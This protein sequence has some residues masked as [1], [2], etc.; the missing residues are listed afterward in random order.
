MTLDS[1][2]AAAD[3]YAF[4]VS[5]AQ[6]RL[7]FLDQVAPNNP[8]YNIPLQIPIPAAVDP[9]HL[10]AAINEIV[11]RH[12]ALR[13]SF[14]IVEG[15]PLQVVS[16]SLRV[17][18]DQVDISRYSATQ[19]DELTSTLAT[20]EARK[21][22]DLTRPPLLRAVLLRRG[23]A[24]F[25]LLLT[26]HHIVA[27]GWSVGILARELA[28]LYAAFS[29]GQPSPLPELP[30]QYADFAVWQRDWLRGERLHSLLEYW[31]RKLDKAPQLAMPTDR[32]RPT[33]LT[34]RGAFHPVTVSAE[35]SASVRELSRRADATL[36]MTLL[37]AFVGLLHRYTDQ[38]DIVVGTPIANRNRDEIEGLIGFFV[39]SLVMRC[40][41]MDNPTFRQLL[42][43]VRQECLDAYAHQ[44]LPFEKLVEHL[45]TDR[46]PS[47]NPLFQVTFQV[48]NAPT[49]ATPGLMTAPM[50]FDV[51]RGSAIFDIAFTMLD[52]PGSLRGMLEYST[53]LFDRE[54]IARLDVHY[55][56]FLQAV[57]TNPDMPLAEVSFIT[58]RE[59]AAVV[60]LAQQGSIGPVP[61]VLDSFAATVRLCADETA[62]VAH[63]GQLSYR[64]LDQQSDRLAQH[65]VKLGVGSGSRVGLL[66]QPSARVVVGM[67]GVLKAGAA[68]VPLDPS[69]PRTRLGFVVRDA[70]LACILTD[71]DLAD[72]L[73][74]EG[75]PRITLDWSGA[76]ISDVRL[77]L[78]RPCSPQDTAYVIYTSGSTGS[79]KGVMIPR[80]AL[81]NH[82][83]WMA[84]DYPL[85][86][87]DRVLQR[88]PYT[89]DASVW[90]FFAPMIS[91]ARLVMLE[92]G[93]YRDPQRIAAAVVQHRITILQTVPALLRLL[94]E[95]PDFCGASHLRTVFCGGDVLTA[96]LRDR[97]FATLNADLCN[98]YGPTESTIDATS[99]RCGRSDIRSVV[100]I[101]RAISNTETYVLDRRRE[102][103]PIGV[104]GDLY[105]GGVGLATGYVGHPRLTAERFVP[106][107]FGTRPSS[108][109]YATGDRVRILT[110]GNL[111]FL[112]RRDHQVKLRGY[113]VELGEIEEALSGC[114]GV[115]QCAVTVHHAGASDPRLIGYVVPQ[116]WE[117]AVA[118]VLG[119]AEADHVDRWGSIYES[120]YGDLAP[121]QDVELNFVGWN[122]S[123]TGAPINADEMTEWRARTVDGILGLRPSRVLEIGCGTGLILYPVAP[124]CQRYVGTDFSARSID[125]LRRKLREAGD[126]MSHVELL[127]RPA[128]DFS[129]LEDETFDLVV[130][131]SVIQYF[132][133]ERY[134]REV[135]AEAIRCLAP[136]GAVFVG[137][138]RNLQHLDAFH[139]TVEIS[140]A[141]PG[142]PA[143]ELAHRVDHRVSQERELVVHPAL[144]SA[145]AADWPEIGA[146]DLR[147]KRSEF[148]NELTL[149]RY[150]V[151]L[152]RDD[153]PD[154]DLQVERL[155]WQRTPLDGAGLPQQLR[156]AEAD[157]VVVRGVPNRRVMPALKLVAALSDAKPSIHA[158]DLAVLMERASNDA[159]APEAFFEM[160]T[161]LPFDVTVAPAA[162]PR[163][164]CFDAM[165]VRRGVDRRRVAGLL[166]H[167]PPG[168]AA[169]RGLSTNP[170]HGDIAARLIPQIRRHLDERLPEYMVPS[171]FILLDELPL[172]PNGKLDRKGLPSPVR[173]RPELESS[174]V[175]P[176]NALEEVLSGL[177]ANVLGIHRVG[178]RDDFFTEL[179]GHSLLATQLLARVREM[180]RIEVPLQSVFQFPTVEE[181]AANLTTDPDEESRLQTI[182]ILVRDLEAMSDDELDER[183]RSDDLLPQENAHDH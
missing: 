162:S 68:Y 179:G 21:P 115:E 159:V 148:S 174:Y 119:A 42:F 132:P 155:D 32:P 124:H 63:D 166:A 123:Y 61:R 86:R 137:D 175:A 58:R 143:S 183:L 2:V 150:D 110:D 156:L 57:V 13:T 29:D 4:P 94:L 14:R 18:L 130:L 122:S 96:D 161:D 40:N 82:M 103:V 90:E 62:V 100:P 8:F 170:V 11:R 27:D 120:I 128:H 22:F 30:I 160:A 78:P 33:V 59:R 171:Q 180:F 116:T 84:R 108:P 106:N 112:G 19:R 144:F 169:R 64:D 105:L 41:V 147:L 164:G 138:V 67:V 98:L 131:N 154:A 134:L 177:W 153:G 81:D 176:R 53:D 73:P 152:H 104:P 88:T 181:F 24:D 111:E 37:A 51:Q 3:L 92:P 65:L 129:L 168:R 71:D 93:E 35:L 52:V 182:A 46:D 126:S 1:G 20:K 28:A 50:A 118:A 127:H 44:D 17:P 99:Y 107:G 60:G 47:R 139:A 9:T 101:G 36:F 167:P 146:V 48:V 77:D 178:V 39:N 49:L 145:L 114:P 45:K 75:S 70:E 69:Y 163:D 91:G 34:Y 157:V 85:T 6:Q 125:Y 26:I 12:E 15:E 10:E 173:A 121:E 135:L 56:T 136:G 172:L 31:T 7:W 66:A 102:I 97:F 74:A 113:R 76:S 117:A 23:S 149:F 133:S 83:A 140:G 72:R 5:F 54:T 25:V 79:P 165:F 16:Q 43:R 38:D 80:S 89:F 55:R 87:D 151:V 141:G 142:L 158:G 95:E 109:L